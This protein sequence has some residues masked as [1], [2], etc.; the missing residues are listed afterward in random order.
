MPALK[1]KPFWTHTERF[2]IYPFQPSI[3]VITSLLACVP[4]WLTALEDPL[5]FWGLCGAF[6]LVFSTVLFSVLDHA[7]HGHFTPPKWTQNLIGGHLSIV[8]QQAAFIFVFIGLIYFG[9]KQV[10]NVFAYGLGFV[11]TF[12][13][14][15][16]VMILGASRSLVDAL[17]PIK[18]TDFILKLNKHYFILLG[19]IYLVEGG[20]IFTYEFFTTQVPWVVAVHWTTF[21]T[22][23][24]SVTLFHLMGYV[25]YL[26]HDKLDHSG[27]VLDEE[28]QIEQE[29]PYIEI[30]KNH[31]KKEQYPAA[32]ELLKQSLELEPLNS[33][34]NDLYHKL[35]LIED[36]KETLISH[37]NKYLKFLINKE[38]HA[39]ALEVFMN[40]F[41]Q[42]PKYKMNDM[43]DV[44][45]MAKI[46][47]E[48]QKYQVLVD[49]LNGMHITYPNNNL[50]PK[51]YGFLA[52]L[53]H[54]QFGKDKEAKEILEFLL[55]KYPQHPIKHA[56][57]AQLDKIQQMNHM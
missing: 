9:Q 7:M 45:K 37:G 50:I 33:D 20:L 14:P 54:E 36:D 30:I 35:C 29:H 42:Y 47:Q 18:I 11:L 2:F 26:N 3:A 53:L 13:L 48:A 12:C 21:I 49:F 23:F 32:K 19:M 31:I 57:K 52:K 15:A 44:I 10:G 6:I 56:V 27:V 8:A 1:K 38:Y 25:A 55:V 41:R 17:N 22:M 28:E 4:L 5:A 46:L 16:M 43:E 34:L 39:K 24:M 51:A 40:I